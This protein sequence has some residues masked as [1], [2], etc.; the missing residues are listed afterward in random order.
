MLRWREREGLKR[1]LRGWQV[2]VALIN[3]EIGREI[4]RL[5]MIKQQYVD[6]S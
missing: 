4:E 6:E 5:E 2:R 3:N 1:V